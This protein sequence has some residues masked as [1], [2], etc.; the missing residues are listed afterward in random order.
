M[1]NVGKPKLYLLVGYPGAGKTTL[2]RLIA[3]RTGAVHLWADVERHKLFGE[4][5]HSHAESLKLYDYLNTEAEKLL[6]AG[7]SVVFD[8]NFNFRADRDLLREIASRNGAETVVIWIQLPKEAAKQRVVNK[9]DK[10][11][12]YRVAMTETQFD[13]ITS[14]LEPPTDDENVI[15]I[16]GTKFDRE[17]APRLLGL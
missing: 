7:H 4:A 17:A 14:K 5:T 6:A 16:D 8:T 13:A 2:S 3:E 10:R 9:I 12:G 15:K 11:N 1:V